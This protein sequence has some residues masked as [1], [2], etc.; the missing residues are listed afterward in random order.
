MGQG[1][2]RGKVRPGSILRD[3]AYGVS[4]TFAHYTRTR[5]VAASSRKHYEASETTEGFLAI[6][7]H[8]GGKSWQEHVSQKRKGRRKHLAD[9]QPD[10]SQPNKKG[11][12]Y[13]RVQS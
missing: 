8:N 7:L 13:E 10:S 5:R 1:Y 2:A 12:Y 9:L 11:N 6:A 4:V 3:D